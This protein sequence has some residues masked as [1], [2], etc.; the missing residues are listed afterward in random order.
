MVDNISSN[1]QIVGNYR[2]VKKID[3]GNFGCVYYAEHIYLA[4][5]T[6]AIKMMHSNLASEQ[7][8][9]EFLQEANIL[10]I[11][12][13]PHIL[14]ILDVGVHEQT[15]PYLVLDY[16]PHGS[17]KHY[18]QRFHPNPPPMEEA[19]AIL[20]HLGQALD[21]A[22]QKGIVHRDL[23]PANILFNAQ[24]EGVLSDFGIAVLLEKTKLVDKSGTPA[25]MAPEQ[26]QGIVSQKSDQF[27]LGCIAY[28]LVTGKRPFPYSRTD[29]IT[30]P[31]ALNPLVPP[32]V[33]QAILQALAEQHSDRHKDVAAF[34]ACLSKSPRQWLQEAHLLYNRRRFQEALIACDEAIR[35]DPRDAAAYRYKGLAL[36]ALERFQEALIACDEAI[37]LDPGNASAYR[38]K[39]V[40]LIALER[41]QEALIACDEAIRLDPRYAYAY[42]NKGVALEALG[43]R[44]EATQAFKQAHMIEKTAQTQ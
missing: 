5:R 44:K 20:T 7:K 16:C 8:R 35:L 23:K 17:L 28:E 2:L 26:F 12:Q 3:C 9:K 6:A 30:P 33:E 18:L 15:T 34:I 25:Y 38:Y 31:G 40:A 19:I 1:I 37:R 36:I 42:H 32:H 24:G 39:G 11:L 4:N 10:S 14:P 41:F 13:H 43:R 27:A 22:H 21:H 29:T